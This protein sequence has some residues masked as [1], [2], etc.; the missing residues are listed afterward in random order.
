MA[1]KDPP[2]DFS[3]VNSS[4]ESTARKPADFSGV[5]ATVEST[6]ELAASDAPGSHTVQA[7]DTLSHIAKQVYGDANAW[8]A[9][10]QANRDQIEDPDLIRPGQVLKIPSR[11]GG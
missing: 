2:A 7:G 9:I 6:A 4:V 1:R 5:R 11:P 8:D 10:F 3:A